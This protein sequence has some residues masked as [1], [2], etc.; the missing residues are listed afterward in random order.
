METAGDT[1]DRMAPRSF[2]G[3]GSWWAT[4]LPPGFLHKDMIP[5]NL[6]RTAVQGCDS[7]DVSTFEPPKWREV[8]PDLRFLRVHPRCDGTVKYAID[9]RE[10]ADAAVWKKSAKS[11]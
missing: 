7:K 9:S 2:L 3:I 10:V 5:L 4:S 11:E 6:A 1:K 8:S